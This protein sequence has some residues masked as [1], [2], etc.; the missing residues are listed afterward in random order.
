[1][2]N[3]I[4]W[5]TLTFIACIFFWLGICDADEYIRKTPSAY[6]FKSIYDDIYVNKSGD[7]MEGDLSMGGHD[8]Y[9]DPD[10]YFDY[11]DP[12]TIKLYLAG[13]LVHTWHV[14]LANEF[15]LLEDGFFTLLETGDKIIIE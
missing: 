10:S 2:G 7:T 5:I 8:F 13:T 3:K 1:M 4:R 15:I 14:V 9:F 12:D 6:T 11:I